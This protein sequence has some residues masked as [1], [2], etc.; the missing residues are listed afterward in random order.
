VCVWVCV[1][2]RGMTTA[3]GVCVQNT[4]YIRARREKRARV[5]VERRPGDGW[6]VRQRRGVTTHG[7]TT[8]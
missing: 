7:V 5:A 2:P 6:T 8:R 1:L 3:T 4:F